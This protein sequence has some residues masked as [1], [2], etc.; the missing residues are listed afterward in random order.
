MK[1]LYIHVGYILVIIAVLIGN[2]MLHSEQI[3][4]QR[5]LCYQ[6]IESAEIL[7]KADEK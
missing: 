2:S 4:E 6:I 5:D 3:Q 7:R 1:N